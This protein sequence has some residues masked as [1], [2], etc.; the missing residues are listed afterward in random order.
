VAAAGVAALRAAFGGTWEAVAARDGAVGAALGITCG[1]SV[2]LLSWSSFWYDLLER[3]VALLASTL[4]AAVLLALPVR[5]LAGTFAL[6]LSLVIAGFALGYFLTTP[7]TAISQAALTGTA[8]GAAIDVGP[9]PQLPSP[10]PLGPEPA[11]APSNPARAHTGFG[12]ADYRAPAASQTGRE[13]VS[14]C[15]SRLRADA[16]QAGVVS[17]HSGGQ[18]ELIS[19]QLPD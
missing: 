8:H 2:A 6:T 18:C 16:G 13:P 15:R 14:P 10:P 12:H 17:P 4:L 9:A 11:P 7:V 5:A 19:L 1:I 3:D